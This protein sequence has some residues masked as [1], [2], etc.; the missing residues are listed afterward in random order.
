MFVGYK[1]SGVI[2]KRAKWFA[3]VSLVIGIPVSIYMAPVWWLRPLLACGLIVLLT[4]IWTRPT[5]IPRA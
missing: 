4:Y 3:T 1:E 5:S 2:P